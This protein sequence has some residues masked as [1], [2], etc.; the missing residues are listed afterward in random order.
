MMMRWIVDKTEF[1]K[2]MASE[3]LIFLIGIAHVILHGRVVPSHPFRA[4]LIKAA[5]SFETPYDRHMAFR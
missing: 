5:S 2:V 4:L 1:T 3:T